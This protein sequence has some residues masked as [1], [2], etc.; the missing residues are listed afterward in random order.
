MTD[1]C[2]GTERI[3]HS[4]HAVMEHIASRWKATGHRRPKYLPHPS[5][6]LP[7][8]P[9][10]TLKTV[11]HPTVLVDPSTRRLDID[12]LL[13]GVHPRKAPNA[14]TIWDRYMDWCNGQRRQDIYS[15]R[16]AR[17]FLKSLKSNRL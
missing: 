13:H 14:V 2:L 17:R 4:S 10:F 16:L 3:A 7:R 5:T 11:Q 12:H 15:R 9:R 8:I 1:H 6:Y